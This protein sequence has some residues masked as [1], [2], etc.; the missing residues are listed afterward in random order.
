LARLVETLAEELRDHNVQLNS[1]S[2][3]GTY[4]HMTDEILRAGERAGWKDHEVATHVRLTGGTPPEKQLALALFLA[5]ER[6]NHVSGKL[7]HVEDDWKKLQHGSVNPEV[8]TLR[9]LQKV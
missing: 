7:I 6:S 1:M 2:P 5:S 4:T 3:G 8:F 9:R